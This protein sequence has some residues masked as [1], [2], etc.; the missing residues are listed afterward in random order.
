MGT[1]H[2]SSVSNILLCVYASETTSIIISNNIAFLFSK[3][4]SDSSFPVFK[5]R[6]TSKSAENFYRKRKKDERRKEKTKRK[7]KNQREREVK[8]KRRKKKEGETCVFSINFRFLLIYGLVDLLSG[9][10]YKYCLMEFLTIFDFPSSVSSSVSPFYFKSGRRGTP[11]PCSSCL[12]APWG[13]LSRPT[14][15]IH[16]NYNFGELN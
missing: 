3:K 9:N 12:L 15:P 16:Q 1:L 7:R 5:I 11:P 10:W 13:G 14:A 8:E 4:I 6:K 2:P